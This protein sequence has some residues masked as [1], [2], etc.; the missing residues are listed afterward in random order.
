MK[1]ELPNYTDFDVE[2]I[3]VSYLRLSDTIRISFHYTVLEEDEED[4]EDEVVSIKLDKSE[5][6]TLIA[7]LQQA[8][9]HT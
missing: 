5:L 6:E 2:Q 8:A 7:K 3:S 9:A 1:I 4:A